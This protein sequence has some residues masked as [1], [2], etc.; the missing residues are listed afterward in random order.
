MSKTI[1]RLV[2]VLLPLVCFQGCDGLRD[3]V[4]VRL[5]FKSSETIQAEKDL[6]EARERAG[7]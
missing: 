3:S 7:R 4:G 6:E 2:L 5:G 1:S